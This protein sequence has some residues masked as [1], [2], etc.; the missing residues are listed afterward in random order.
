MFSLL[1]VI[2]TTFSAHHQSG[3]PQ[4]H[5]NHCNGENQIQ[6]AATGSFTVPG[7]IMDNPL[8]S[9]LVIDL[10]IYLAKNEKDRNATVEP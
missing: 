8:A 2:N 1:H 4:R 6:Q 9:L 3:L 5:S 7:K 10:A